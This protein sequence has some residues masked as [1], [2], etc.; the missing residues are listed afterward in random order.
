[1]ADMPASNQAAVQAEQRE[2]DAQQLARLGASS[3]ALRMACKLQFGTVWIN[4][5]IPLVNEMPHSG[6]KQRGYGKDM[7][8]Y[9]LAEYTQFKH[10]I[11]SHD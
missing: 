4:T 10:V 7:G 1:M 3:G 2:R 8:I 5:H 6:Y 11:A 9:S